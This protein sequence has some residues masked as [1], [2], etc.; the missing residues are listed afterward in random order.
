MCDVNE[1]LNTTWLYDPSTNQWT[2]GAPLADNVQPFTATL[3]PD[4]KVVVLTSQVKPQLYDPATNTWTAVGSAGTI[5]QFLHSATLLPSGKVL[6]AGG[7]TDGPG[8]PEYTVQARAYD[9]TTHRWTAVA[10]MAVARNAH[11]AT[12][13]SNGKV[14]VAGEPDKKT[15]N[16]VLEPIDNAELYD[17][18]TDRWTPAGTMMGS[19]RN[20]S[21]TVLPSG[22]LLLVGE[23]AAYGSAP[24]VSAEL[25]DPTTN[26]WSVANAPKASPRAGHTATLLRSGKVLVTGG[27]AGHFFV[28]PSAELYD[29]QTDTWSSAGLMALGRYEHTATLL[30]NG[31]V[32]VVGGGDNLNSTPAVAAELYD[33]TTN[34]W[35][36]TGPLGSQPAK[37]PMPAR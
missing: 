11:T 6:V 12:L 9:P 16:D 34:T 21:A 10:K 31:K 20:P 23:S 18:A 3:L 22:K 27:E 37:H 1:T 2:P 4:G 7:L 24:P 33:P 32:L 17:P 14:L 25:Y 26:T 36:S 15:G 29:P 5:N 19:H 28:T 35:A 13:L 8:R 30:P